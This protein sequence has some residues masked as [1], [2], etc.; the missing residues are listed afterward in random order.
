MVKRAGRASF[1]AKAMVFPGGRVDAS[2]LD[3]AWADHCNESPSEAA[4]R[5]GLQPEEGAQALALLV[6]A[7]RE[8]F[9]EAGL[10]LACTSS[11]LAEGLI[12]TDAE[13][14][15]SRVAAHR[16]AVQQDAAHFL[17]MLREEG[18]VLATD[19]LACLARWI[20]PALESKLF[21]TRFFAA[22]APSG[23]E[24]RHD[25][26]ETTD[27]AWLTAADALAAYDAG[28]IQLAPPTYRTLLE[29]AELRGTEAILNLRDG[30]VPVTYAPRFDATHR[31]VT[32]LLPGDE[33]EGGPGGARHR[34]VM[35]GERWVSE[36]RG[37]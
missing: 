3:P 19:A 25:A 14:E 17:P 31:E 20:T 34:I 24:G 8:T 26:H 13:P 18:L 7:A 15:T 33:F 11:G 9:G 12:P 1:M 37:F 21:D 23:Q 32:L 36:G 4:V 29:L 30:T 2:D 5:L 22:R 6:A 16:A 27:S 35:R 28:Q 10:L